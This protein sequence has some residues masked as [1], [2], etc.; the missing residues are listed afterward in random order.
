MGHKPKAKPLFKK[1]VNGICRDCWQ[2]CLRANQISCT[3]HG[4]PSNTDKC[5]QFKKTDRFCECGRR[6]YFEEVI[7]PHPYKRGGPGFP[8]GRYFCEECGAIHR[9]RTA[10]TRYAEWV[11]SLMEHHSAIRYRQDHTKEAI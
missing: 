6:L 3:F 1:Y 5:E 10:D 11:E 7:M 2:L 8:S 4:L 9:S